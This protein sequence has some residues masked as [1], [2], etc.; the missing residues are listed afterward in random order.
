MK[1]TVDYIEFTHSRAILKFSARSFQQDIREI[2]TAGSLLQCHAF[3][4]VPVLFPHD[5]L[6]SVTG[7][8][9]TVEMQNKM[10][11]KNSKS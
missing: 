6:T 3:P 10:H 9:I 2:N 11:S 1:S 5:F 4:A 8:K 7:G